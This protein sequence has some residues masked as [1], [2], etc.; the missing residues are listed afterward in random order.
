MVTRAVY[1]HEP[2]GTGKLISQ[3]RSGTT[4]YYLYDGLGSARAL[5]DSA[6][7]IT[8]TYVYQAYGTLISETGSTPN[9]YRYVG[10]YG[11]YYDYLAPAVPLHVRARN[12]STAQ[13]RFTSRDPRGVNSHDQNAYSYVRNNPPNGID[14]S[15]LSVA[16]RIFCECF[17]GLIHPF[18]L[19]PF[20]INSLAQS[21]AEDGQNAADKTYPGRDTVKNR[22]MRHCVA[23]GVLATKP[24]VGCNTAECIGTARENA[25]NEEVGQDPREGMRGINNNRLGRKCAGC[26]GQNADKAGLIPKKSLSDIIACC[27]KAIEAGQADLGD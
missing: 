4:S 11:Y 26:T 3:H 9:T 25:Q 21:A 14:P 19:G 23:S 18:G 15:G 12:L 24:F 20:I 22:A 8:D 13:A 5:A 17:E 6:G 2:G 7:N 10:Q 16:W 1:T 27:K